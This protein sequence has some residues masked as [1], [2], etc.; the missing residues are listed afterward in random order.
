MLKEDLIAII[1]PVYNAE[2]Y[3]SI[4]IQSIMD[5]TYKNLEI[6]LVDDGSTDSSYSVCKNFLKYDDRIKIFHKENAGPLSAKKVGLEFTNAEFVMFVDADDWI[7]TEMCE[8]LYN[9]MKDENVD[10]V[11]S[12]IIRYFSEDVCIYDTDNI[13]GGKYVGE[14]YDERIIPYMLCDGVFPRRGIDASLAIK[15][16]RRE[17]L[18]PVLKKADEQY[19]HLFAEDTAVL[20]PYLLNCKS[21]YICKECF[22]YHR[23][24]SNKQRYYKDADFED[25]LSNLFVYLNDIFMGNKANAVLMRQLDYFI[26]GLW[27]AKC[28]LFAEK[29]V[30][31][32]PKLQQY[33]FPFH[34]I[35]KGSSILLYGA[36]AVGQSFYAQLKKTNYCSKVIWQDKEY[37]RYRAEGL[38]VECVDMGVEADACVVAVQ[39]EELACKIKQQLTELGF[40]EKKL[41]W[42]DPLLHMW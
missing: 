6:I 14:D 16:F 25:K 12:G 41:V 32:I 22:Y 38:A 27:L 11:T 2:Q 34:L 39:N 9:I 28:D 26:Y 4:C 3:L 29:I 18:L 19:G 5:Q 35:K 30:H 21:I 33:L 23:Q 13:E 20:Y 15:M 36:G 37:E 7:K 42:E 31:K 40:E 24:Y 17:I 8:N 10:L 1:V